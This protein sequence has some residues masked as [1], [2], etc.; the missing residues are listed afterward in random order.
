MPYPF[1]GIEEY[2]ETIKVPVG[3]TWVPETVFQKLT[4]PPVVTQM[5]QIIDPIDENSVVKIK[6]NDWYL[7]WKSYFYLI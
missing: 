3:R 1:K 4:A 5:G 7:F 6:L 2:E